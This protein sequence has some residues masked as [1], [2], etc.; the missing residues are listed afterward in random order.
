MPRKIKIALLLSSVGLGLKVALNTKHYLTEY[1]ENDKRYIES[2]IQ[3]NLGNKCFCFSKIRKD[4]T[5]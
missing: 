5:S 1:Q 4:I 3:L 2:W